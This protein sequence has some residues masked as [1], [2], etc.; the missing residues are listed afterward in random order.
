MVYFISNFYLGTHLLNFPFSPN[1]I[2]IIKWV[3]FSGKRNVLFYLVAI[4]FV[5]DGEPD[6]LVLT[7]EQ[8]LKINLFPFFSG[9]GYRPKPSMDYVESTLIHFRHGNLG[10]WKPWSERLDTFLEG[11]L[12]VN[13]LKI[14]L[15]K[16]N[17]GCVVLP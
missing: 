10:D 2:I 8:I 16:N 14:E 13:D 11:K 4:F 12:I 9:V 17:I 3:M 7:F 15:Q 1:D 5:L 6:L